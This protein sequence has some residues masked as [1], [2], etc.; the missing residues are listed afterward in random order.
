MW[1]TLIHMRFAIL[2]L[3]SAV[4]AGYGRQAANAQP[5]NL[6]AAN[7]AEAADVAE[8]A[9]KVAKRVAAHTEDVA[10]DTASALRYTRDALKRAGANADDVAEVGRQADKL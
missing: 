8:Q 7:A 3:A 4:V 2:V 1:Q 10:H 5:V 6:H 9:A